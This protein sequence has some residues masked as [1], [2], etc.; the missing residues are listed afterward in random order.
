[1]SAHRHTI[2]QKLDA[3]LIEYVQYREAW[4]RYHLLLGNSIFELIKKS[5][6]QHDLPILTSLINC[7]FPQYR[8]IL[9][10]HLILQ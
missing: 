10:K 6:Q 1:M 4:Y 9:N 7:E 8:D 3:I 2:E 5:S